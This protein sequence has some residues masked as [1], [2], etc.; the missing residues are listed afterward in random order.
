MSFRR[1]LEFLEVAC[2]GQGGKHL[3]AILVKIDLMK[4][5]LTCFFQ[6]GKLV[7]QS[8]IIGSNILVEADGGAVWHW[9]FVFGITSVK[10]TL[11]FALNERVHALIFKI[12]G[13][14]ASINQDSAFL[15]VSVKV[16]IERCNYLNT[17]LSAI[18]FLNLNFSSIVKHAF[19]HHRLHWPLSLEFIDVLWLGP[20]VRASV[21]RSNVYGRLAEEFSSPLCFF[22]L[23]VLQSVLV[24]SKLVHKHCHNYYHYT[25]P[26]LEL[27][28]H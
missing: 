10:N 23:V 14:P 27:W 8:E 5:E 2:W 18:E 3:L 24:L 12:I 1:A 11:N 20:N 17:L 19:K 9:V 28:G 16:G 15:A 7:N 21:L 22:L 26:L 25:Y 6:V 13:D 4:H